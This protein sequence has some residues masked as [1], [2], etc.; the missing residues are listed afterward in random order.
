MTRKSVH[1]IDE[2]LDKVLYVSRGL[3]RH[4]RRL[5][6]GDM[7]DMSSPRY[8]CFQLKGIKCAEC[9]IEG[10]FFAKEKSDD[11]HYSWHFNLYALDAKGREVLMTKDHIIP[12]KRGGENHLANFQTMCKPC[13]EKKYLTMPNADVADRIRWECGMDLRDYV[14]YYKSKKSLR[15]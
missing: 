14:E 15:D 10:K 1:E 3:G 13:N 12:Y 5:I 9:G 7:M 8:Q 2:V 11:K 4:C 6:G